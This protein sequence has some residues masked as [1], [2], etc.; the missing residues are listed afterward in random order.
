MPQDGAGFGFVYTAHPAAHIEI[1]VGGR[2]AAD[3]PKGKQG[4]KLFFSGTLKSSANEQLKELC[5]PKIS[6]AKTA[7]TP[8]PG[9]SLKGMTPRGRFVL[10]VAAAASRH[11][12]NRRACLTE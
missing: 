6:C 1:N 12:R 3:G 8:L 2:N 11:N 4:V 10:A 9:W 7:V 5:R